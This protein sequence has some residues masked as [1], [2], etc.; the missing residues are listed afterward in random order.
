MAEDAKYMYAECDQETSK[1]NVHFYY[2]PE[3]NCDPPR[4]DTESGETIAGS[5]PLP[6]YLNIARCDHMCEVDG[7]F[8]KIQVQ[9]YTEQVCSQ[10]PTN[11]ISI[12]G[13]FIIDAL[14]D[15]ETNLQTK[16]AKHFNIECATLHFN[17][18]NPNSP[19]A[20]ITN[21]CGSWK[22]TGRSIKTP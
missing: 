4:Q 13:G 12:N 2:D 14:M 3:S 16:I 10:C 8:S 7:F 19:L 18:T 22:S 5:D 6:G 15:D 21:D 11:S 9:P 17:N 1:S 20:E